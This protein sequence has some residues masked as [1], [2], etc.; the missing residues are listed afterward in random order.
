MRSLYIAVIPVLIFLV[1]CSK[2]E[3]AKDQAQAKM[4]QE[5]AVK[6]TTTEQL[7]YY[8][9]PMPEHKEIHSSQPG[10]CS[11]CKMK[12][13]KAVVTSKDK[14]EFYGCPMPEH[15]YVRQDSA[16]TCPDCRMQ[17]KPMRLVTENM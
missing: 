16:G 8:T 15:S 4:E 7:V 3:S 1:S 6:D 9:C 11:L 13:V 17:L 14:A 5:A 2:E 10:N 12:L